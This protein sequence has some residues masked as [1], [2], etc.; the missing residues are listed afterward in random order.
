[1]GRFIQQS[2][3]LRNFPFATSVMLIAL[4]GHFTIR[5]AIWHKQNS[6][7]PM[8]AGQTGQH[9]KK[10]QITDLGTSLFSS[11]TGFTAI[12]AGLAF[13]SLLTMTLE[14][15]N[16]FP[17]ALALHFFNTI[18]PFLLVSNQ[19]IILFLGNKHLIKAVNEML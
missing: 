8:E 19:A 5:L 16:K 12:P 4:I 10:E 1:M 11:S 6:I 17:Q 13:V 15:I 18:C 2:D 7:M 14:D 3:G 9:R